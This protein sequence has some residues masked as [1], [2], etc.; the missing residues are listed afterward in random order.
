MSRLELFK[1]HKGQHLK[2][3]YVRATGLCAICRPKRVKLEQVYLRVSKSFQCPV[4]LSLFVL[5]LPEE[6][7]KPQPGETA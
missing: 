2:L 5:D 4:C 1:I 7:D 6:E 3:E